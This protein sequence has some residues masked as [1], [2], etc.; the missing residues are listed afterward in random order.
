MHLNMINVYQKCMPRIAMAITT[1]LQ[2]R[3]E[4]LITLPNESV[5]NSIPQRKPAISQ[6]RL[7]SPDRLVISSIPS[8]ALLSVFRHQTE[9]KYPQLRKG[10]QY[11]YLQPE[12]CDLFSQ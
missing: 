8:R 7:A 12:E 11:K 6:K 9:I 3:G 2:D 1:R 4:C 5:A 10:H